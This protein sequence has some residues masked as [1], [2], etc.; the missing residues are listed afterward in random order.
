M[1]AIV[2]VATA[3]GPRHGGINAFNQ[4]LAS[5]VA[6]RL[7]GDVEVVCVV[8]RATEEEVHQASRVGVRLVSL[9]YPLEREAFDVADPHLLAHHAAQWQRVLWWIGH[10]VVSG[11]VAT[12]AAALS[13][14][15]SA[16]IQHTNYAAY[17]ALKGTP[18]ELIFARTRGEA[19]TVLT[20]DVVLGVGPKLSRAAVDRL[21]A[22][23]D[24]PQVAELV[25]GL[26]GIDPMS[27]PPEN[28]TA[29]TYGRLDPVSDRLKQGTL[30]VAAFG[31][32]IAEA[33]DVVG[34]DPQLRVIGVPP[35][36]TSE[37]ADLMRLA[38]QRAGRAV[39][40]LCAPFT[41]SR[42]H[43]HD[44]LRG[45]SVCLMLSLHEGFGLT[46]WEAVAAEVPLIASRNSGLLQ[47]LE[48]RVG[49]P[50]LGCVRPIDVRGRPDP[51]YFTEDDV[52]DV[53]R[54]LR[55]VALRPAAAKGD[56]RRLRQLV[57]DFTWDATAQAF[58]AALEIRGRD[59]AP[60]SAPTRKPGLGVLPQSNLPPAV[61]SF[62]GRARLL[63]QGR[64]AVLNTPGRLLTLVGSA[65]SGKTRLAQELARESLEP[66]DGRVYFVDLS[67]VADPSLV[68]TSITRALQV[69]V[70]DPVLEALKELFRD[71]RTLLVLDNF[72]QVRAA[73]LTLGELLRGAPRLHVIATSREPLA[74]AE[75]EVVDLPALTAEEAS[76]LFNK[77]RPTPADATDEAALAVLC[78]R[79]DRLPLAIELVAARARYHSAA[80][81]LELLS[82]S[83]LDLTAT[84][85][86]VP[87]RQRSLRAAVAW[88][89]GLLDEPQRQ[90]FRRLAV[91]EGGWTLDSAAAVVSQDGKPTL[92]FADAMNSLLDKRLVRQDPR[93]RDRFDMLVTL[94]EFA[95]E[96][97]AAEPAEEAL[98]RA[99][100]AH[101]FVRTTE[102]LA[103][104]L[105]GAEQQAGLQTLELEQDN[106]KV[107]HRYLVGQPDTHAA[108]RLAVAMGPFW[109]S[110]DYTGGWQ[111]LSEVLNLPGIEAT[112]TLR[113]RA[114]FELG[115]IGVRLAK[116]E[117]ASTA[118]QSAREIARA[119]GAGALE[120]DVCGY[121]ALLALERGDA[122]RAESLLLEAL[123]LHREHDDA[124]GE[125]DDL[126]GLGVVAASRHQVQDAERWLKAA[127]KGYEREHDL[128]GAA[129]VYNDLAEVAVL[130]QRPDEAHRLASQ[131]LDEGR[132]HQDWGMVAWAQRNSG[133]AA[134]LDARYED[135]WAS[136]QESL[137]LFGLLGNQRGV[138]LV[139]EA[140]AVLA[141]ARGDQ[142][143][144][145][146][147]FAAAESHRGQIGV[148]RSVAEKALIEGALRDARGTLT[149][150]TRSEA[151][152]TRKVLTLDQAVAL[153][154]AT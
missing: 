35:P 30:A 8:L 90:L 88:S 27:G 107:A 123:A 50:A 92:R 2:F 23:P 96:M 51:P 56:A 150:H 98:V 61:D 108:L 101:H 110:R 49:G 3:W 117:D 145:E 116:L 154:R 37:Q 136:L 121:T 148:P 113:A 36:G 72:E 76:D 142:T 74:I 85:Q 45:A 125:A 114:M 67:L 147:L 120:A 63:S 24:P 64:H 112:P 89:H 149:A 78:E 19:H 52:R 69:D 73:A 16:V 138:V 100:H 14:S 47:L 9:D 21:R 127:L 62:V 135:A 133:V 4:D 97:L 60:T 153:A 25:P 81:L 144:A 28:F 82:D 134:I 29:I 57:A 129:W 104:C 26:A 87:G 137:A 32:L 118:L 6:G 65:G 146:D 111:R 5:A 53:T 139:L 10:D 130:G 77:R 33:N 40:V 141:A 44:L 115:R 38:A 41:E 75:E 106:V 39:P 20:A 109:W 99:R 105:S 84:R 48:E 95:Q 18:G 71:T 122:E 17:G 128:R 7:K 58:I 152:T 126:D 13:D 11:P 131:A 68:M 15:R 93:K 31:Q 12:R 94:R 143:R 80:V 22:A 83:V 91:F 132:A 34:R 119:E 42:P 54:A 43:L 79:L 59:V 102:D 70:G 66:F 124:H 103:A 55:D 86:D 1:N 140:L 46:G 151:A